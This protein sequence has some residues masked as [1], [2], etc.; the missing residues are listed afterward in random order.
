VDASETTTLVHTGTFGPV[1]NPLYT[2]MLTFDFGMALLTPN[3]VTIAGFILAVIALELQ[4]RR[5]EQPYLRDKHGAAYRG[6][7]A[8]VGRFVPGVGLIR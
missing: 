5:V 2:A 3:F 1:R 6:H 7:T 8:N 4:V